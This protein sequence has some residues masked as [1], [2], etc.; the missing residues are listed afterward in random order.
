MAESTTSISIFRLPHKLANK[1]KTSVETY[2]DFK[3]ELK[4]KFNEINVEYNW[5][6][7]CICIV[8]RKQKVWGKI[9]F[10]NEP[11]HR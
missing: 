4:L 8:K 5:H 9:I 10:A 6:L 11:L 1:G 3:H 2:T 7:Y